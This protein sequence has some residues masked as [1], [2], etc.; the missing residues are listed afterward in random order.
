[1]CVLQ[2]VWC[3]ETTREDPSDWLVLLGCTKDSL[4]LSFD[5]L[6]QEQHL[7]SSG[8]VTLVSLFESQSST[9]TLS[10]YTILAFDGVSVLVFPVV[11]DIGVFLQNP[12]VVVVTR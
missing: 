9:L 5:L 4:Q 6:D 7:T 10:A 1:M 12:G 8:I 2:S 3:V 11:S